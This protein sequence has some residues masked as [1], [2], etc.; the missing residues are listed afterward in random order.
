MQGANELKLESVFKKMPEFT[1]EA[2][3]SAGAKE[4][5]AIVG[6]SGIGK[7]TLLR[8]ISGL[9]TP[10]GGRVLL[11]SRELTGVPIHEREIGFVFQDKALFSGKTIAEN[12]SF[13]LTV[14]KKSS[15]ET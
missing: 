8:L 7:T 10:D 3:F 5:L 15:S 2:S 14:R 1:L 13:G 9:E 12:I 4:R 6:R 11:G